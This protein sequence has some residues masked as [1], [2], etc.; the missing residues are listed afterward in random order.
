VALFRA[1]VI[2]SACR[3]Y[4]QTGIKANRAYTPTAMLKAATQITGQKYRRGQHMKAALDI[5]IWCDAMKAAL[6]VVEREG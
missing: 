3:L 6:P 1:A 2:A 5:K 4:A